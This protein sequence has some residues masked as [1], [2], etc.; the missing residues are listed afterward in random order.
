MED[1]KVKKMNFELAEDFLVELRRKFEREDNKSA[2][3]VELKRI[4]GKVGELSNREVCHRNSRK[5]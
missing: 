3:V 4:K 2:K 1:I 5:Q